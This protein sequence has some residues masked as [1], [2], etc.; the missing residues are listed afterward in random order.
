MNSPRTL[1]SAIALTVLAAAAAAAQERGAAGQVPALQAPGPQYRAGG[2]H[3]FLLGREYRSLW[4][5]PVSAPVLNLQTFAGGLRA[6]SKGGGK[7]TRS[8]LLVAADGRQFFFRA[9]D[10]DASVLLPEELRSTVAG[11]VVRDQ[12]SSALP[13]APP[14]VARL[15]T[16]AGILHADEGLFVLPRGPELGEFEAEFGGMMG[17]LQERIGG[18]DG[19]PGHWNGATEIIGSDTLIARAERSPDD[20]V[21]ARAYAAARL[22]D[23]L[24]GDWD[25]HR[26]QWVWVRYGE[27]RPHEWLPVPRDRDQAFAKYD[28]F[29]FYFA[30]Q[31]APQLTNFGKGYSYVPGATWNGRDLDRRFLVE[32]E[33][34]VWD[35][36]AKGLQAK[37]TDAVINDAVEALPPEHYRLQGATLAQALRARRDRLPEA[38]KRYYELL[39]GQVDVSGTEEAEEAQI[40]RIPS[41]GIEVTLSRRDG[42]G[43]P[44]FTRRFERGTTQEVRVFLNGGDDSAIVRGDGGGIRLR[45]LGGP[46]QDRLV[47]SSR[48]GEKFYD[49]PSGP[50]RTGGLASDIDRRP[51]KPPPQKNPNA[52]PPRDW[53]QRWAVNPSASYGPDMGALLGGTAV[54]TTYGFR[55]YPYASR[56]LV[57]AGFA[58]G[59][60]TY[61]ADYRGEFRRENSR[62]YADILAHASGVDVINFHGFGNEIAAPNDREFY[63]VTQDAF[64]LQPALAFS[65]ADGKAT[66]KVGPIFKYVSTDDRAGRFLSTLGDLYGTGTFGEVGG[67][68]DL[69]FDSRDRPTAATRGVFLELGGKVYPA[70][71]DVDSTF[72]EVHGLITTYLTAPVP[73]NPTLALRAGGRKLWGT[74]PYFEA[75]FIGDA[76]NVRLGRANRYAGDA[77]AYGS[78]ELRLALG[79]AQVVLPAHVGIFGLTDVG[80]VFLEG[81]S[82]DQWHTAVGGGLWL[83]FLDRAHTLSVAVASSEERTGVYVQAGFGF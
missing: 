46:G 79:R 61:R 82:S 67:R 54:L 28:G 13:T 41:G 49:D 4:T 53:G 63:R 71:W 55:K 32:L 70:V 47:D 76:S 8:L 66:L 39:A 19:P 5:T 80:R 12:T 30:R 2:L 10:K 64:G 56:H 51:Y 73:L 31:T 17:F 23:V 65:L 43:A 15:L 81:E 58:T 78:A 62:G 3:R 72:G 59:P 74:Y 77:S 48:G 37:L 7:Q 18:A 9:V 33:R 20:R 45:I 22:F 26:D 83:A 16:A 1:S 50:D 35:S 38:A 60:K 34:P 44:Y 69:Q 11:D 57:R 42:T 27:A 29:L 25:R 14:V 52:P 24:I 75:A 21:N 68:L 36:V 6:V 40:T